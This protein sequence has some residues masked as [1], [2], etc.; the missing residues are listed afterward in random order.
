MQVVKIED[1][2]LSKVS[3]SDINVNKYGGKSVYINYDNNKKPLYLSLPSMV[4]P[5]GLNR[6]QDENNKDS[7][8]K[9]SLILSFNGMESNPKLK[10]CYEKLKAFDDKI[11]DIAVE[12]SKKWFKKKKSK[13]VIEELYN[14]I[15]LQDEEKKY[16]PKFRK[17]NI[18]SSQETRA[19][20]GQKVD[21]LLCT[22][23]D[24]KQKNEHRKP[25]MIDVEPSKIVKRTVF[26]RTLIR[27]KSLYLLGSKF[28]LTWQLE[29]AKVEFPMLLNQYALGDS[30]DEDDDDNT[31]TNN[32]IETDTHVEDSDDDTS[33]E[34]ESEDSD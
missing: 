1:F 24:C 22:F 8:P 16:A 11:V 7:A 30:D 31:T 32:T 18:R 34:S 14:S 19:A 29:Q 12:N 2:D 5:F 26:K 25:L 23:Y 27:C 9:F 10:T 20:D 6:W 13:A 15:I 33:E 17:I 3:V 21:K 28:G 4:A